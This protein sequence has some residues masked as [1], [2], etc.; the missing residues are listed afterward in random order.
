VARSAAIV[1]EGCLLGFFGGE[2]SNPGDGIG[3][4]F[5]SGGSGF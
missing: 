3:A 1:E 2:F 4:G 5:Y